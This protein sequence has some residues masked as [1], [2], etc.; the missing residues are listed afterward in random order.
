MYIRQ[1]FPIALN[2]KWNLLFS[3]FKTIIFDQYFV[4]SLRLQSGQHKQ[5]EK[6]KDGE[7]KTVLKSWKQYLKVKKEDV[8]RIS[9]LSLEDAIAELKV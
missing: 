9:K 6:M 8:T 7:I 4:H 2:V 1:K 3:L 5:N